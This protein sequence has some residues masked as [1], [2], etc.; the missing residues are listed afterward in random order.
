[1]KGVSPLI[2]VL[3][4]FLIMLSILGTVSLIFLNTA[5]N[6]SEITEDS[7]ESQSDSLSSIIK[8]ISSTGNTITVKN[9]G[10]NPI[11]LEDVKITDG[12]KVIDVLSTG[13]VG[14]GEVKV[15]TTESLENDVEYSLVGNFITDKF[16]AK[17]YVP[18]TCI[19]SN[20]N[21]IYE[22]TEVSFDGQGTQSDP[23]QIF[24]DC[25]LHAIRYNLNAHYIL[26]N[27]IDLASF[28]GDINDDD[29]NWKPI[30]DTT[31]EFTGTFDGNRKNISHIKINTQNSF[32]GLFGVSR[33]IIKN[34]GIVDVNIDIDSV[35][36]SYGTSLGTERGGLVGRNNGTIINS[37]STGSVKG[38]N[39]VG[40]LVGQNLNTKK[41]S[42]SYS[43][44]NVKGNTNVGGLVGGGVP[45]LNNTYA[46]G[47]VTGNADHMSWAGGLVGGNNNGMISNSYSYGNVTAHSPVGG[48][49]GGG[50][51]TSNCLN[52]YWDTGTSTQSGSACG[53]GKST[54]QLKA[55]TPSSSIF[56]NWDADVWNFTDITQYPK[57]KWQN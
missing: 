1:M 26:M 21:N 41:I 7:F 25:Q 28:N 29:S 8:V 54:T 36:N 57:L 37:S 5:Q 14:K 49:I 50:G 43:S 10:S 46:N 45:N 33:G 56:T 53:T 19:D 22:S 6:T 11:N 12:A 47:N 3:L 40:G 55:G 39:Y 20:N 9:L 52:S 34:I 42:N 2:A 30:G 38:N 18:Y 13:V 4:M 44:V 17:V 51:G 31:N 27:N 24:A 48:L 32:L 23:N 35:S 16:T 15:L